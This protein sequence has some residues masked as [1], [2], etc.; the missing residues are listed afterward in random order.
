MARDDDNNVVATA[1]IRAADECERQRRPVVVLGRDAWPLVPILRDRGIPVVYQMISRLSREDRATMEGYLAE[2]LPGAIVVDTGYMGSLIDA[3]R[4]E[5]PS[6]QGLLMSSSGAYP[7]VNGLPIDNREIVERIEHSPKLTGRALR[8]CPSS[9]RVTCHPPGTG[10]SDNRLPPEEVVRRNVQLLLDCGCAV[11]TAV[12]YARFMGVT[13]EERV[14]L[15]GRHLAAH[16]REVR[17]LRKHT[18]YAPVCEEEVRSAVVAWL[19]YGQPDHAQWLAANRTTIFARVW[20]EMDV[21]A[22]LSAKMERVKGEISSTPWGRG[23][24][25]H[26][27]HLEERRLRYLRRRRRYWGICSAVESIL[28]AGGEDGE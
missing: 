2:C 12:Q 18:G 3:I 24:D 9:G 1:F 27:S 8:T 25:D 20:R 4:V 11:T 15:R 21:W 5:D 17:R 10:D 23:E 6:A 28:S 7:E 16:L 19:D 14:G 26:R 22:T 13:R